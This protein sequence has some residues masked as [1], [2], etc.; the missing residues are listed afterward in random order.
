M[1]CTLSPSPRK[2]RQPIERSV[3]FAATAPGKG[4][5]MLTVGK[6]S[7]AY[8]LTEVH[9]ELAGR[10]FQLVKAGGADAS[11][12]T[13]RVALADDGSAR[14]DCCSFHHRGKCKHVDALR[15]LID[16]GALP[17]LC[18]ACWERFSDKNGH[19]CDPCKAEF[20]ADMAALSYNCRFD[21]ELDA[22]AAQSAA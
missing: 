11:E 3:T 7:A 15:M 20:E 5:L 22:D 2:G 8:R 21:R 19:P 12:S 13:Y 9:P 14:C 4:W 1:Q 17:K 16:A 6:D 18:P 10:A